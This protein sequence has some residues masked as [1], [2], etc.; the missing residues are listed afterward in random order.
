MLRLGLIKH[1]NARPLTYGFEQS[2]EHELVYDNPSVLKDMLLSG[3]LDAALISSVECIRNQ[4][5]LDY[6]LSCGVCTEDKVRSILFFKNKN[7]TYP[8]ST[9]YSDFGSRTS[10][11]LLKILIKMETGQTV[12]EILEKPDKILDY[13]QNKQ[14]SHLLFGDNA[15]K[16]RWEPEHFEARDMS[17]WWNKT[18]GLSFCYAFWAYPKI[19]KISDDLF[20]ES[21]EYGLKHIDEIIFN[22]KRFPLEFVINY[23]KHELHYVIRQKDLYGFE[24]YIQKAREFGFI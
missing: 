18:T 23:L 1:L 13:I 9:V 22:E 15:L 11:T 12:Q 16:A 21:L 6:S 2:T 8:P 19:R 4:T 17:T 3:K 5:V 14:N 20:L 7:E 10:I 24:Y